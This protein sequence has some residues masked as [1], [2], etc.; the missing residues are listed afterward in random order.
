[1]AD[2]HQRRKRS[3][4]AGVDGRRGRGDSEVLHGS[5]RFRGEDDGVGG[6]GSDS[7]GG[8]GGV[9]PENGGEFREAAAHAD[10]AGSLVRVP[11]GVGSEAVSVE[12]RGG[13]ACD[14]QLFGPAYEMHYVQGLGS[15]SDG[16]G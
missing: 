7:V 10:D 16:E 4:A 3:E 11:A 8:S 14:G 13:A 2:Q 5:G 1:M 15:R 6:S 9:V 12:K